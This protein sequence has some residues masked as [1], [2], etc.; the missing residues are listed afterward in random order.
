[1]PILSR[2]AKTRVLN[3]N[4]IHAI[5]Y[6]I[7]A[8]TCQYIPRYIPDTYHYKIGSAHG[9]SPRAKVL[10]CIVVCIG[11]Y[12]TSIGVYSKQIQ[13]NTYQY[14]GYVLVKIVVACIEV[15]I[16][17]LLASILASVG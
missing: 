12:L 9:F 15:F 2:G 5:T 13:Y 6:Q 11:M 8:F 1:M 3:R 10:S 4:S 17:Q 7:Y 16:V 14:F